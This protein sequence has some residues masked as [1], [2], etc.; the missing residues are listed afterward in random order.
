MYREGSQKLL[1]VN[2]SPTSPRSPPFP[3]RTPQTVISFPNPSAQSTVPDAESSD[4]HFVR[5]I[6]PHRYRSS[7]F[8]L[9]RLSLLNWSQFG[10]NGPPLSASAR[11]LHRQAR[12]NRYHLVSFGVPSL[13]P[14]PHSPTVK[15]SSNWAESFLHRNMRCFEE[16]GFVCSPQYL[17]HWLSGHDRNS[18]F[19]LGSH[20]HCWF[21]QN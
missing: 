4:H 10:R 6:S 19:M 2:R 9:D 15:R 1:I 12:I 11:P 18:A 16:N 8:L 7:P 5:A 20:G 21:F 13:S 3:T 14:S 17:R